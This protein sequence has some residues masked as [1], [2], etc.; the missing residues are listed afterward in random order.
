MFYLLVIKNFIIVEDCHQLLLQVKMSL[1]LAMM[2][3]YIV[4]WI[5]SLFQTIVNIYKWKIC[6][7]K[8]QKIE[9]PEPPSSLDIENNENSNAFPS[10]YDDI[11]IQIIANNDSS[12]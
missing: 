10:E 4:N 6:Q 11:E 3:L 8:N 1:H 7:Y 2:L 9:F 12:S 5:K